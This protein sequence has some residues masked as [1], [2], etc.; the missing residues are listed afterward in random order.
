MW[1]SLSNGDI[2]AFGRALQ[3]YESLIVAVELEILM[4]NDLAQFWNS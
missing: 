1:Q 3:D 4:L 2:G